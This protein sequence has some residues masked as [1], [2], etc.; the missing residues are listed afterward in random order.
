MS[1]L[2]NPLTGLQSSRRNLIRIGAIVASGIIAK[3]TS[4][5]ADD[6][7]AGRTSIVDGKELDGG[8]MV[9]GTRRKGGQRVLIVFS[10]VRRSGPQM[11]TE[12]S[13]I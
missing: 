8:T 7:F 13:K 3:T 1:R 5:T 10:R 6:F 2:K 11:A 9:G 12:R 4:A